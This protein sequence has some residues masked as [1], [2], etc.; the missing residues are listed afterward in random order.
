MRRREFIMA[1][2]GAAVWPPVA[3]SQPAAKTRLVGLLMSQNDSRSQAN[4]A[5]FRG[6][7]QEYGWIEG[8]NVRFEVRWSGGVI[9]RVRA[10]ADELVKLAP[11][12]ILAAGTSA[13]AT[14]KQVTQSV[15]L[16]FVVVN[17]PVAQGFVAN[18]AH[19]GGNITG[20]SYMDYSV[21]EKAL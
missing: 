15:P 3:W 19:P 13:I 20:F 6:A 10:F 7:R 21:L 17:D 11:D 12:V 8:R 16:V 2:G 18:L 1:L 9:D 5:Q 4:L 14:L